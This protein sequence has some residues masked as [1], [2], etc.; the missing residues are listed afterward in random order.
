[1]QFIEDV[2]RIMQTFNTTP[3]TQ[4]FPIPEIGNLNPANP[5][6]NLHTRPSLCHSENNIAEHIEYLSLIA[7]VS[8]IS[9]VKTAFKKL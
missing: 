6:A 5:L 8:L 3:Q 4:S 1:M 9:A 2:H 7:S